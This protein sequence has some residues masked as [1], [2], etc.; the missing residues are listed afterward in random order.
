MEGRMMQ[1]FSIF[2][3]AGRGMTAQLARLNATASNLANAGSV[4]GSEASAYRSMKPVFRTINDQ[5]GQ[6]TVAVDRVVL[7][8]LAPAKRHAPGHPLADKDG[9]VWD[10]AVDA[11]MELVEMMEAS[12]Q[13]Q[14]NVQVLSTA[15][16]LILETIRIGR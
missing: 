9:F 12:R 16:S 14:N 8:D 4:S 7:S 5:F 1:Q 10:A 11:N 3:I 15:K 13:Y 6:K 2:D